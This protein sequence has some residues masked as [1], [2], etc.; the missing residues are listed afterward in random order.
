MIAK[1]DFLKSA[2]KKKKSAIFHTETSYLPDI[3]YYFI[4]Y[5]SE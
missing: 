2:K 3:C 5:K 4:S 1:D